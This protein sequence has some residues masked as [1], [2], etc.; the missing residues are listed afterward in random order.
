MGGLWGREGVHPGREVYVE[1]H[2]LSP[3]DLLTGQDYRRSAGKSQENTL[4][5]LNII[6]LF[7]VIN[8][9][10]LFRKSQPIFRHSPYKLHSTLI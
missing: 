3:N 5:N 4:R 2:Q 8:L 7:Q 6:L 10:N 1:S 9:V